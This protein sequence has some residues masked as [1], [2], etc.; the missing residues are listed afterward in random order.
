MHLKKNNPIRSFLIY[1]S[2]VI[3][4]LITLSCQKSTEPSLTDDERS[5][6]N[7][8]E[9]KIEVL[10]GYQAPPNA[11]HDDN[12]EYIG[13]VVDYQEEIESQLGQ[14]FIFRNFGTWDELM[15][16]S[17]TA[18]NFI[19]IGCARTK[20]REDYL[21]FTNS[22]IKIPYVIITQKNC[23]LNTIQALKNSKV[24]TTSNYAINDYLAH[25]YPNLN[26]IHFETDLECI[27]AVSTGKCD[28]MIANQMYATY[29][30]NKQMISDLEIVGESGYLNRLAVAVSVNDPILYKI[31]DKTIDNIPQ[32]RQQELYAKW[33]H[34]SPNSFTKKTWLTI[35]AILSIFIASLIIMWLWLVSLR[36]QVSKQTGLIKENESKYRSLIE[37]SNDAIFLMHDKHFELFNKRFEEI[38]GYT[39]KELEHVDFDG[40]IAPENLDMINSR[41]LETDKSKLPPKFELTCI[42]KS[43]K[44]LPIEV[45]VSYLPYKDGIASQGTIRDLSENKKYESE[46][47]KAKENAEASDRLKSTFLAT[48]SHELRTPLNAII[49]FS[50]LIQEDLQ[51]SDI[52]RFS[53]IINSS[54]KHLLGVIEDVFDISLIETGDI[55]IVKEPLDILTVF[56]E[57]QDIIKNEQIL[58]EKEGTDLQMHISIEKPD[59]ILISDQKRIKQILINLLKN[60]LKFT[61]MGSIEFGCA[62][63]TDNN[64]TGIKFFVKD[65]GIGIPKTKQNIIFELFRQA[66]ESHTRIYGGTGLGLTICKRL[67]NLMGG[68]IWVESEEGKGASFYFTIPLTESENENLDSTIIHPKMNFANRTVL[69]AEDDESSFLFLNTLLSREGMSCIWAKDGFEAVE[70]CQKSNQID[71]ILMDINMPKMNGYEATKQIK[72]IQSE[73]PIIAQTAFAI[74]GD[75]EKILASGCDDYISKPINKDNLFEKIQACFEKAVI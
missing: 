11:F 16:Y 53:E 69:I 3:L 37:N 40:L 43:G 47:I 65:T 39:S 52:F 34:T 17:K 23:E 8:N 68:N 41:I 54:G 71:L 25:N 18:R 5:W 66:E 74:E 13:L 46:L 38:L 14:K 1:L 64:Q 9:G 21:S 72:K 15:E 36:N 4:L 2:A 7:N 61:N 33:I 63:F 6:L 73:L 12:G 51:L 44:K 48:M 60:S 58:Q 57:V 70:Y 30:I 59:S 27:R 31:L 75:K 35:L 32:S 56:E 26:L 42:S 62:K 29:I 50:G 24:C 67:T 49:G 45:S 19:I 10:F 22:I 55:K 20:S 28:A